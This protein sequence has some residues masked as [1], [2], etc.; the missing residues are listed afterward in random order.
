MGLTSTTKLKQYR[1][2]QSL[3]TV[4]NLSAHAP[5]GLNF[6]AHALLG[7]RGRKVQRG[8]WLKGSKTKVGSDGKGLVQMG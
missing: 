2:A 3:I 5:A 1:P 8:M 7:A 4:L 6:S